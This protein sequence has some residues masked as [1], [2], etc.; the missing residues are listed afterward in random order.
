METQKT[1]ESKEVLEFKQLESTQSVA[2]DTISTED[3]LKRV[4]QVFRHEQTEFFKQMQTDDRGACDYLANQIREALINKDGFEEEVT[5]RCARVTVIVGTNFGVS[6]SC[7]KGY[8][9]MYVLECQGVT[10]SIMIFGLVS[11]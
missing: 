9:G 5:L 4:N 6:G 2:L 7:W 3:V 10:V 11:R 8:D 1:S